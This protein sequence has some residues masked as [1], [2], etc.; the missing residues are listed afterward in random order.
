MADDKPKNMN[1]HFEW[2]VNVWFNMATYDDTVPFINL[3]T[4]SFLS[5]LE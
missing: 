4:N 3:E 2:N 1:L 5:S